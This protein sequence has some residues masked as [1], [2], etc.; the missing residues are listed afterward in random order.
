MVTDLFGVCFRGKRVLEQPPLFMP[1]SNQALKEHSLTQPHEQER[2]LWSVGIIILEILLGS[3]LVLGLR[4]NDEVKELTQLVQPWLGARLSTLLT[5]LLFEVRYNVVKETLEDGL[6]DSERRV[7][8]AIEE[9]Q[10]AKKKHQKLKAM[11]DDFLKF[12]KSHAETV[13]T[14][15]GYMIPDADDSESDTK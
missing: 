3:E 5:G 4:T 14:R 13:A 12:A 7:M 9:V 8:K 1:Y 10:K 15:H 11:E 2:D 6:L